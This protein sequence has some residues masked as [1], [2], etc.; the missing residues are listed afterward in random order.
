M[1]RRGENI[2]KRKDGRWE[3]RYKNGFKPDGRARYSSVYGKSYSEVRYALLQKK[4]SAN[5]SGIRCSCKFG[6][7]VQMWL[8]SII[9]TVKESTYSNYTM[10]TAKHILPHLGNV[11]YE[12]LTADMLNAFVTDRLSAGL[13]AKYVS[14]IS[15]LIK[16][17]CKFAHTR[18]G[19]DN[20]AEFMV[21]PKT[22]KRSNKR[23]LTDSE[24]SSL[25]T[26]LTKNITPGNAGIALSAATG[27]RIGELCALKWSDFDLEKSILTV[28]KTMQRIKNHEGSGTKIVITSPK[29]HTSLREIPIPE[30][31]KETLLKLKR[32][33]DCFFLTGTRCFV[34]PRTMQYRFKS[35]LKKLGLPQ[36]NFHSLR[37]MFATRCVSLGVDVKTLSEILGHSSVKITLDRYVHSSFERKKVCMKLFSDGFDTV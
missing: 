32:G 18:Y 20:K 1:A 5:T 33:N 19:Y 9:N 22:E 8:N 31:L 26:W 21:L 30:F 25:N 24:Q 10:K 15:V 36:V 7:V 16:S 29:S 37:H 17:V 11:C 28:S 13:S 6:E 34:E 35:I 23:L 2:Y 27:I 3:G 14:D 4:Q 12:K